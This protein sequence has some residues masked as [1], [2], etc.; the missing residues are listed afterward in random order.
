MPAQPA[1]GETHFQP[2][3]GN[4]RTAPLGCYY[5]RLEVDGDA[6]G[7]SAVVGIQLDP[8]YTNLVA[9]VNPA[10]EAA[11]GAEDFAVT[12]RPSSDPTSGMGVDVVSTMP[13]IAAASSFGNNAAF[14][15]YPTPI[16]FEG[17]GHVRFATSN[18]GVLE[19]YKLAIEVLCFDIDIRRVMPYPLLML[20]LP[21][22]SGPNAV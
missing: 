7:G 5:A 9:A 17:D 18:V 16:L 11:A 2:L 15:W 22:T 12:L 8:R 6:S 14:L 19:T 21:G 3:G 13:Q 1:Q 4:G 10:I 20:N